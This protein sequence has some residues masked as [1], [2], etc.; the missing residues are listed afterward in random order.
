MNRTL[1]YDP[2]EAVAHLKV[3]DGQLG[4]FIERAGTMDIRPGRYRSPFEALLRAIAYQQLSGKA[5]ATIHGRVLD[6]FPRRRPTAG[7]MLALS[8]GQLRAAGLSRNKL[9]AVRDLAEKTLDGTIPAAVDIAALDDTAIMER[10]ASVRGIGR[11]TVEMLLI[12]DL[13]RPD[14]LPVNDLGIRKGFRNV[15]GMKRLPAPVTMTRRA[16]RWQPYRSAA[17]WYLWRAA[18][19][20]AAMDPAPDT[21]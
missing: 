6:L 18:D 21:A 1:Q 12:F 11:W 19:G 13:G 10:C 17:S 5:A 7:R 9:L 15:F 16:R 20:P 8:D 4:A 3:V 14:V 2:A